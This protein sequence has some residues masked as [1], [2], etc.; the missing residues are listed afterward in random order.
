MLKA[1]KDK[2]DGFDIEPQPYAYHQLHEA[3]I[4]TV[5][6]FHYNGEQSYL[7]ILND[8]TNK[9]ME[10]IEQKGLTHIYLVELGDVIEGASLRT[11][12]LMMVKS[13]MVNQIMEVADAYIKMIKYLSQFVDIT[14]ISVDSSNHTQIRNLGTKQNQLVEEDLMIIFNR[15]I[16]EAL[17]SLHMVNDKDV[18]MNICGFNMFFAHGHLIKSKEKYLENLQSDR[19]ILIDYGFFGHFH[20]QRTIDLHKGIGYDKKAFYVPALNT[21]NST[22]ENDHN[23]SSQAGVGYYMLPNTTTPPIMQ[24][25]RSR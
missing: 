8:A 22:F 3:H 4:F 24:K 13:G 6:D 9:I 12:Q 10:V 11:S 18:L 23:L 5:A 17:P 7:H 14:F 21:A 20:H 19:N 2:Y 1:I 15:I 16:K 25:I